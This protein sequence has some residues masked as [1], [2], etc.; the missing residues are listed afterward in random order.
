MKSY[1]YLSGVA[2]AALLCACGAPQASAPTLPNPG[3]PATHEYATLFDLVGRAVSAGGG[4][5]SIFDVGKNSAKTP[6]ALGLHFDI[7]AGAGQRRV[8][9][10]SSGTP[11]S[12]FADVDH[13]K[14]WL[15]DSATPPTG[16][17]TAAFG[18]FTIATS[19]NPQEIIFNN[20]TTSTNKYYMAVAAYDSGGDDITNLGSGATI[21]GAQVYV[22]DSGGEGAGQVAVGAAPSYTVSA[23]DPLEVTLT[24]L[25][26]VGATIDTNVTVNDGSA[27]PANPVTAE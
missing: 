19:T 15:I 8:Q 9:D 21:G 20:V 27:T 2:I 18:P 23:I 6:V 16:A 1:Q 25:D 26:A 13:F 10:S 24:L 3:T 17:L 4:T 14:C 7:K 5:I 22:T 12:V 11:N